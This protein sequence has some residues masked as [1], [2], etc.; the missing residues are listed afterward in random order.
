MFNVINNVLR[1]VVTSNPALAL[2]GPFIWLCKWCHEG[3]QD[4]LTTA[5]EVQWGWYPQLPD[6]I[7]ITPAGQQA[8]SYFEKGHSATIALVWPDPGPPPWTSNIV[9][10][11]YEAII[12]DYL[13]LMNPNGV[14]SLHLLAP[15]TI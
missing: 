15:L 1:M 9:S 3:G 5:Y 4:D 11:Q 13:D 6:T 12:P 10:F 8:L 2:L 7:F 14:F